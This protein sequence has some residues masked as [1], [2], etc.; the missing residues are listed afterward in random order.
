MV[1]AVLVQMIFKKNKSERPWAL[2]L[3]SGAH[4]YSCFYLRFMYTGTFSLPKI[5]CPAIVYNESIVD[6]DQFFVGVCL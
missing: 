5:A 6:I 4:V 1:R 3:T 2:T